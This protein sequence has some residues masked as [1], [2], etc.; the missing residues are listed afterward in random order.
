MFQLC[1]EIPTEDLDD[2]NPENLG[3]GREDGLIPAI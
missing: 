3:I 2:R 1:N